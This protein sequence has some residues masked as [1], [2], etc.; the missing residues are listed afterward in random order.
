MGQ[1]KKMGNKVER[2]ES[3]SSMNIQS[4]G[5]HSI[6]EEDQTQEQTFGCLGCSNLGS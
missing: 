4:I 5:G 2:V 1:L 3:S 6:V